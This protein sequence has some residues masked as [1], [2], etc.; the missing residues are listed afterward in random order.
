MAANRFLGQARRVAR[1]GAS[2][3][4]RNAP[5]KPICPTE[6]RIIPPR[7]LGA[8]PLGIADGGHVGQR[9]TKTMLLQ[10]R[11]DRRRIGRHFARRQN[12]PFPILHAKRRLFLRH[13]QSNILRHGHSP[14][15]ALWGVAMRPRI[16]GPGEWPTGITLCVE[17]PRARRAKSVVILATSRRTGDTIQ[18][19]CPRNSLPVQFP[20]LS[21]RTRSGIQRFIGGRPCRIGS[22]PRTTA[23]SRIES[24]M[25]SEGW[26]KGIVLFEI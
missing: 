5:E 11:E 19:W 8:K 4:R 6:G 21:S 15:L 13:V 20:R 16:L 12:I 3:K 24:G 1:C 17:S 9:R 7:A 14:Y 2:G 22:L 25:T 10:H 18:A 23:G 26:I